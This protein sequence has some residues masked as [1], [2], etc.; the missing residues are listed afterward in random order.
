MRIFHSQLV[1][2]RSGGAEPDSGRASSENSA[3]ARRRT[4]SSYLPDRR[5]TLHDYRTGVAA[6]VFHGRGSSGSRLRLRHR[7][8]PRTSGPQSLDDG[9]TAKVAVHASGPSADTT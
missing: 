1:T 8:R 6:P 5:E 2:D 9:T 7:S 3:G 4:S